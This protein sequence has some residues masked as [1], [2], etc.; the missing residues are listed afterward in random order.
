MFRII[1]FL[2]TVIFPV[3]VASID[4]EDYKEF[5]ETMEKNLIHEYQLCTGDTSEKSFHTLVEWKEHINQKAQSSEYKKILKEFIINTGIV[6]DLM[7]CMVIKWYLDRKTYLYN[8]ERK[9]NNVI[10]VQND[11]TVDSIRLFNELKNNPV[12]P[13]DFSDIPIGISQ[14][15][16]QK[17][18]NR[19]CKYPLFDT[20]KYLFIEHYIIKEEPF[21][22]K[23]YFTRDRIYCKYEILSYQFSGKYL[24]DEVRSKAIILKEFMEEKLGA[25]DRI[26]RLGYFDIKT[27][28]EMTYAKWIRKTH[29]VNIILGLSDN[30]YYTRLTVESKTHPELSRNRR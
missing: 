23:F 22:V 25:A 20:R 18:Y 17:V 1:P 2:I 9:I 16:F 3:S 7:P 11:K 6:K 5:F 26:Y 4:I 29:Y 13:F 27:D 12:T 8:Y 28:T 19:E 30:K 24:N 15:I 10:L 14:K 21:I